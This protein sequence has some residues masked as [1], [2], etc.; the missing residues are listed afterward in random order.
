MKRRAL[1]PVLLL[2][3]SSQ[4]YAQQHVQVPQASPAAHVGETFGITEVSVDYHRPT[5]NKRRIFGGLVPYDVI[6]RAGANENTLVTFTTAVTVEG[7]PLAAGTYS[8]FYIPGATQWTAVFNKFT[9]GWGTYSYDPAEDAL[10][11]NVTPQPVEPQER[12]A[13]SFEDGKPDSIILSMRWEKTRVPLKIAADTKQLTMAG[14][15]NRLRSGVHWDGQAWNE[16]ARYAYRAGDLDAALSWVNHSI[17]LGPDMGNLRLKAAIVEKQGDATTAKELRDRAAT[18]NPEA[19]TLT[20]AFQLLGA[21]KYDEA[22]AA[23]NG[24][25]AKG[26]TPWRAYSVLGT[27]YAQK[28]DAAKSTASFQKAMSLAP[29]FSDKTEVQDDLNALGAE[30]K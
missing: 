1:F 9:G 4:L 29:T 18:L 5:V 6:W 23:L 13:Y 28:G 25:I 21:K 10:R 14:L 2:L 3:V 26:T 16:A 8:F 15:R 7:Q 19:A 30:M 12:M 24:M 11:V 20:S 17:D 27:L 22:E